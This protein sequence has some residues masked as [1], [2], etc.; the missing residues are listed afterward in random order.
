MLNGYRRFKGLQVTVICDKAVSFIVILEVKGMAKGL[1]TPEIIEELKKIVGE[2]YVYTDKDKLDAYGHDEVTD[3]HYMKEAQVAV[4]PATTEEV[5]KVVK[6]CYDNDIVMVPRAAGTGLAAGAVAI[7]GGVIISIERMNKIIEIDKENMVVVA[8][9]GITTAALQEAV[10]KEGLFYAGDPC[11]GDSCFIGG[12][13]A[14]N[15]GGNRAVKYGVTRDQVMGI[16][17]V[18]PSGEVVQLGGKFR[19]NATGYMLMHLYIGCEGT[20]GIVTKVFL[21]LVALPKYEMDLLAVFDNLDAAI[22][23]TPKVMNAGITPVCVEFM[24]NASIKQVEVFLN[25]KLQHSDIGNY[26]IIQIAGDSEDVLDEQCVTIDELAR[27]NGALD[28]LV[29]D[30]DKIWKSRKAYLE[31]DR[32]RSLVFSMED[33]VV[34]M[35][36]IPG[37]VQQI[38]RLGEKYDVAMHCA[39]HC[40]D[41]NVHID[42]LKDDRSQEE[43]EEM[44]PKI[45]KEIYALVYKLGGR[46]SGEHGI[47]YKRAKLMKEYMD[48]V[49]MELMRSVKK[50]LDPKNIM[51][52][53]KVVDVSDEIP[54]E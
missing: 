17:V 40:G 5:A 31:A 46:L 2:K 18:T 37:A 34:P 53:G 8:E 1:V 45:Q 16:E 13:V 3:P 6:L 10:N 32:Q 35:T 51:N 41:G 23:L 29:A 38:S 50:A 30:K 22:D 24:D 33:I 52:P 26:I 49:E 21:K 19:K 27:E 4:L 44:L 15:A 39:G 11:S 20:L 12:N 48:P 14:T 42:I 7:Y 43:W 28:V 25:E 54:V 47:G 36:E 9:P